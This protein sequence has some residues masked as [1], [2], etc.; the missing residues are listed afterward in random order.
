MRIMKNRGKG[1]KDVKDEKCEAAVRRASR[2]IAS[3]CCLPKYAQSSNS[4]RSIER[5]HR[6]SGS[7][8][9]GVIHSTY[10]F[11]RFSGI[12]LLLNRW[13][14]R[15]YSRGG[16]N[17]FNKARFHN[18]M[19]ESGLYREERLRSSPT[20]MYRSP[21]SPTKTLKETSFGG[22]TNCFFSFF[23]ASHP[24][25]VENVQTLFALATTLFIRTQFMFDCL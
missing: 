1:K 16:R 22:R 6:P 23:I 25:K 8:G 2:C 20:L 12:T 10:R 17:N 4:I 11:N 21:S 15:S 19:D 13:M 3:K 9:D 24:A 18:G 7:M 14:A 5:R